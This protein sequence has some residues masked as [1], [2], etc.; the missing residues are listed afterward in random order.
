MNQNS[1]MNRKQL[2]GEVVSSAMDKTVIVKVERRFS[3]PRYNKYVKKSKRYYAHDEKNNCSNG[4]L[5]LIEE[6]KPISKN[7]RWVVKNLIKKSKNI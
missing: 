3:H 7:K 5:I 2:T 1:S 4:D 6:S